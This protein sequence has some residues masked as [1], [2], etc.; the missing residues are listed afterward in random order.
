MSDRPIRISALAVALSVLAILSGTVHAAPI[1]TP[2]GISEGDSYRLIF[3]TSI[4]RD[5]TSGDI[6]DYNAFVTSVANSVSELAALGT[7]WTA[8]VSTTGIDARDNT[9][10]N[11][12]ADGVGEAIYLLDG[13]T[14]IADN[15]ADLWDGSIDSFLNIDENGNFNGGGNT[16]TGSVIDGTKAPYGGLGEAAY[17]YAGLPNATNSNWMQAAAPILTTELQF[18]AISGVL[19]ASSSSVP[20]PGTLAVLALGL[21]GMPALRRRRTPVVKP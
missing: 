5:G 18:F 14:K 15:Y 17:G 6:A 12:F 8:V 3:R 7:T 20:L 19:P 9:G 21:A 11:P 4:G 13:M 1:T 16:W 10:T 2:A